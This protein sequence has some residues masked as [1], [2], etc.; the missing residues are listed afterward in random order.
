MDIGS[1]FGRFVVFL[2]IMI[3]IGIA[4][5][6]TR[7]RNAKLAPSIEAQLRQGGPQT[8]PALAGAL[9]MGGFFSRGKVVLALNEL[10]AA[11]RVEMIPAPEGTPQ[12]QKVN[13]IQYRWRDG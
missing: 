13:H 4:V 8:L 10:V 6:I 3:G 12:L 11:G 5:R 9:G 7:R 2:S 1:L